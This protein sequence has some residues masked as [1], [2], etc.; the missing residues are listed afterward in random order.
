MQNLLVYTFSSKDLIGNNGIFGQ[1]KSPV[2]T[3]GEGFP[4]EPMTFASA[5]SVGP[6]L[7]AVLVVVFATSSYATDESIKT[8][9][10]IF[11]SCCFLLKLHD[12][13]R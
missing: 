2:D 1:A 3:Y 6:C 13:A 7:Q 10:A 4:K 8:I 9:S 12:T 11:P 5:R